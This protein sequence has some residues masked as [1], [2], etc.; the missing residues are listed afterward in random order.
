M[1]LVKVGFNFSFLFAYCQGKYQILLSCQ[2]KDLFFHRIVFTIPS[3][4][5]F[6]PHS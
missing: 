6:L 3:V 5:F 2:E 1:E 4:I